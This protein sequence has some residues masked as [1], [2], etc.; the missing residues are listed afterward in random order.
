MPLTD[1]GH[2]KRPSGSVVQPNIDP[3]ATKV[4]PPSDFPRERPI[5]NLLTPAQSKHDLCHV[6]L[7]RFPTN[8]GPRGPPAHTSE[9][10]R[11]SCAQSGARHD[12]GSPMVMP[13][14]PGALNGTFSSAASA[15]P[16][17]PPRAA[18]CGNCKKSQRKTHTDGSQVLPRHLVAPALQHH[19]YPSKN[20]A[21]SSQ[22]PGNA[23]THT[24][25]LLS[26]TAA[27]PRACPGT[28]L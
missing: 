11:P 3:N 5:C 16:N 26:R 25:S 27:S 1:P 10:R 9:K 28:P 4:C 6:M 24:E 15:C 18:C 19:K 7:T 12:L 2:Q 8:C 20:G 13:K 22:E 17:T 14:V 23:K 21:G